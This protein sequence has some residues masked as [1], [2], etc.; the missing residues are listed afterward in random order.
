MIVIV[1]LILNRLYQHKRIREIA[2][3]TSRA[4]CTM[5]DLRILVL[6]RKVP[7]LSVVELSRLR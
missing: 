6:A 2:R 7:V 5:A 3:M 1:T 4:S